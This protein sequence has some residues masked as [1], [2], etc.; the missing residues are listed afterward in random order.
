MT[1]LAIVPGKPDIQVAA[2]LR[3]RAIVV[4]SPV[5][6]L[7]DEAEAAGF[8]IQFN[9]GPGGLGR[10]VIQTLKVMKEFK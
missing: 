2:E 6:T 10:Q 8:Q 1:D 7:L 3:E 9:L 5:L 4:L